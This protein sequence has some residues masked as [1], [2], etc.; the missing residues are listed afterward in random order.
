VLTT[1]YGPKV[2]FFLTVS[3]SI[4]RKSTLVPVLLDVVNIRDNCPKSGQKICPDLAG[5]A[6]KGQMPEL[7]E[8]EPKSGRYLVFSMGFTHYPGV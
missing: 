4:Y 2:I 8:L 7:P 3:A 1:R 5:C 6:K